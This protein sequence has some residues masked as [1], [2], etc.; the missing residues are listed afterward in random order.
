MK[1]IFHLLLC[2]HLPSLLHIASPGLRLTS[3]LAF[4]SFLHRNCLFVLDKR[5]TEAVSPDWLLAHC[6]YNSI[7]TSVQHV[8]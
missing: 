6:F 5:P 2:L 3:L 7:D 1:I 4:D 8:D